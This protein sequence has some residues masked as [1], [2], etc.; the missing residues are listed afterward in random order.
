MGTAYYFSSEGLFWLAQT[1]ITIIIF[2]RNS[3]KLT[4]DD[5]RIWLIRIC[6]SP[7][8]TIIRCRARAELADE[9]ML[10]RP[11]REYASNVWR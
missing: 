7:T 6:I 10:D 8:R 2:V 3:F 11:L 1:L 5:N 4:L 9:D